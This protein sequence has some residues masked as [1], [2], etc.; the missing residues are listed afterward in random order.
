MGVE[1]TGEYI[2]GIGQGPASWRTHLSI[3]HGPRRP[4][5]NS[6]DYNLPD[7]RPT[8]TCVNQVPVEVPAEPLSPENQEIANKRIAL[9]QLQDRHRT[10]SEMQEIEQR[11]IRR[12]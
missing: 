11:Q 8:E 3:P 9:R 4:T 7:S 1:P 6:R 2:Q 10:L 12:M 5:I